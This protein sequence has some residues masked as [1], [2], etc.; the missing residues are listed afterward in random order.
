MDDDMIMVGKRSERE[1]NQ[2]W[3]QRRICDVMVVFPRPAWYVD[4]DN[5]NMGVSGFVDH[6]M[7]MIVL[8]ER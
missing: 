8:G 3:Y 4:M 5:D 7:V 1:R 6:D 2:W